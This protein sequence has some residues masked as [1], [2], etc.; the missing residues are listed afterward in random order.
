MGTALTSLRVCTQMT[1]EGVN[2]VDQAVAQIAIEE[3][4]WEAIAK[5]AQEKLEVMTLVAKTSVA[6]GDCILAK[7]YT[8]Q[9]TIFSQIYRAL[10]LLGGGLPA[11]P[12]AVV[13]EALG[14]RNDL[15][16]CKWEAEF[17]KAHPNY[18]STTAA[19]QAPNN[20]KRPMEK[21]RIAVTRVLANNTLKTTPDA[22]IK[23]RNLVGATLDVVKMALKSGEMCKEV[24][25]GRRPTVVGQIG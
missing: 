11:I 2:E 10:G 20:R 1:D 22:A 6:V 5:D 19:F 4:D 25:S 23:V 8:F 13:I 3:P 17:L 18:D 9:Q 24:K 16:Y 21:P 12:K 7:D 14:I 15:Q